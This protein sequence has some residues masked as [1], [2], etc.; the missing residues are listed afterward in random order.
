VHS[1]LKFTFGWCKESEDVLYGSGRINNRC[2]PRV[3]MRD[4]PMKR[5]TG[6]TQSP[7]IAYP[8]GILYL[9]RRIH[10][11]PGALTGS[12]HAC[13]G[14]LAAEALQAP[15]NSSQAAAAIQHSRIRKD[16][17]WGH[18]RCSA[19]GPA[20]RIMSKSCGCCTSHA[21]VEWGQILRGPVKPLREY[22]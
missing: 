12:A 6:D 17:R 7:N 21:H 9:I 2:G 1:R 13:Q 5:R 10:R 8:R 20:P 16:V 11:V 22:L 19:G 15:A 18:M 14:K 3:Q 4:E